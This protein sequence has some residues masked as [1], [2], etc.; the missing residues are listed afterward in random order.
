MIRF[1]LR[2]AG[3]AAI[4]AA[5]VMS[6]ALLQA[7]Q[8][9]LL[10]LDDLYDPVAR[11]N[12]GTPTS[13]RGGYTW[14]NNKEYLRVRDSR[15]QEGTRPEIVRVDAATGAETPLF[16]QTRLASALGSVPGIAADE[17]T[18]LSRLRTYV[19]NPART[20]YSTVS[21]ARYGLTADAPYPISVA[22]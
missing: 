9:K 18:R 10:T 7:R 15:S 22:T 6:A 19:M 8:Q 16:D 4:A 17:A 3:L 11:V 5:A 1:G 12:F 2:A 21:I 13:P 14:I 20:R